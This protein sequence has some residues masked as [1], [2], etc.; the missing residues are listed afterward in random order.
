ML[1]ESKEENYDE[2]IESKRDDE[3]IKYTIKNE[4]PHQNTLEISYLLHIHNICHTILTKNVICMKGLFVSEL[5]VC[6]AKY[7]YIV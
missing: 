7:V 5:F 4:I 2:Y 1:I 3:Y 6:L